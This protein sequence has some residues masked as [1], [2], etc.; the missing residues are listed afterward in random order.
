MFS[1]S[2][3]LVLISLIN[4]DTPQSKFEEVCVGEYIRV[5]Q[6]E[7]SNINLVFVSISRN[8]TCV[9]YMKC[10]CASHN[11]CSFYALK[12]NVPLNVC[13]KVAAGVYVYNKPCS[14]TKL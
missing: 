10:R 9:I 1:T 3:L 6:N 5:S 8:D 14:V 12:S 11:F 2:T 7:Y 13:V 4:D